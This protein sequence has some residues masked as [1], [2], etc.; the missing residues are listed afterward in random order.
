MELNRI[1]D[2]NKHV[3][4]LNQQADPMDPSVSKSLPP[5]RL[6]KE[7]DALKYSC[8]PQHHFYSK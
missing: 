5:Q 2:S 6:S 4:A 8:I 3:Q 1:Y 7:D